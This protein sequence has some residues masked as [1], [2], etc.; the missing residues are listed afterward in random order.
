MPRY[1][2]VEGR[3]P[4]HRGNVNILLDHSFDVRQSA[5]LRAK[6]IKTEKAT[7]EACVGH[8]EPILAKALIELRGKASA[9]GDPDAN[10][11][12]IGWLRGL[13]GCDEVFERGRLFRRNGTFL[14]LEGKVQQAEMAASQCLLHEIGFDHARQCTRID[15]HHGGGGR[16]GDR[17]GQ[18]RHM[19]GI[20]PS[21]IVFGENVM[22]RLLGDHGALVRRQSGDVRQCIWGCGL[23]LTGLHCCKFDESIDLS[24]KRPPANA[25]CTE[26]ACPQ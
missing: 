22:P 2:T 18:G 23:T 7:I 8:R 12:Q 24:V 11:L 25:G 20:R 16:Q 1:S 15:R 21:P 4:R 19:V 6:Q 9:A 10:L 26:I 14:Q 3:G 5:G 13:A 17:L